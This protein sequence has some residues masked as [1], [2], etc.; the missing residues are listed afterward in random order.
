MTRGTTALARPACCSALQFFTALAGS[1]AQRLAACPAVPPVPTPVLRPLPPPV[2]DFYPA[3]PASHTAHI[4]NAAFTTLMTGV[5]AC[6]DWDMCALLPCGPHIQWRSV[7][8]LVA[9]AATHLHMSI[10]SPCP[11]S[12]PLLSVSLPPAHVLPAP[13]APPVLPPQV[14]LRSRQRPSA[15]RRAR[16]KW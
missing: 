8:Q 3:L 7:A 11:S 14:P 12:P 13:L 1:S 9:L 5:L 10:F 16:N 2:Q 6:P 15:R 4:A